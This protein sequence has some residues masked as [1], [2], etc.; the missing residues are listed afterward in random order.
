MGKRI[1]ILIIFSEILLTSNRKLGNGLL[2][3]EYAEK[4]GLGS[5]RCKLVGIDS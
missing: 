4:I 5:R 3:L 2:T 1:K